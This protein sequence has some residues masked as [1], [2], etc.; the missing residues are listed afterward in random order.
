MMVREYRIT[1]DTMRNPGLLLFLVALT[2]PACAADPSGRQTITVGQLEQ[3]LSASHASDR[4]VARRLSGL[5]LAQCLSGQRRARLVATLPGEQSRAALNVLADLSQFL[6]P[7][8][9]EIVP[10][11]PPD[12]AARVQI[13]NRVV[14]FVESA[15][16]NM[17]NLL[18]TRATARFESYRHYSDTGQSIL[19]K[20]TPFRPADHGSV[21]VLY[22][23]GTEV[24]ETV[25]GKTRS[26]GLS[27]WGEFGPLLGV[28]VADMLQGKVV[29]H[30]WEQSSAGRL[31]V[32]DFEV[33]K[34]H[35]HYVV[36]YCCRYISS[37]VDPTLQ[38]QPAYHGRVAIDPASGA[39]LRLVLSADLQP[40]D[41]ITR[42]DVAIEYGPVELGGK[43]YICPL[44]SVALSVS[45]AGP[46]A[47]NVLG[48]IALNHTAFE[49]YHLFRGDM[50][51]VP[52][53]EPKQP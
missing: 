2:I 26:R 52:D 20:E 13:F 1:S 48:V 17:P 11:F 8:A 39:I 6:D 41:I 30:H 25:A 21:T 38:L 19:V 42:A 18:A 45:S 35:S 33:P 27:S 31:A 36:R 34:D 43:T 50:R 53:A 47:L 7:P 9:D 29:F 15:M 40:A 10:M 49:D 51:M 16:H 12:A 14:A 22:R 3:T 28:I 5:E 32:F 37:R 23:D 24:V 4:D 46:A 44:R